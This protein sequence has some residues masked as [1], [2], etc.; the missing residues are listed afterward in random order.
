VTTL[1]ITNLH[2]VDLA[3]EAVGEEEPLVP[4]GAHN[5]DDLGG[6]ADVREGEVVRDSAQENGAVLV[7]EGGL[8]AATQSRAQPGDGVTD[9]ADTDAI[10]RV[11]AY[12]IAESITDGA[13]VVGL[14]PQNA[15]CSLGSLSVSE[16]R[17]GTLEQGNESGSECSAGETDTV[18]NP[19]R[20]SRREVTYSWVQ[21]IH[22]S[23]LKMVK[24]VQGSRASRLR[25]IALRI[26][27]QRSECAVTPRER[28]SK[29]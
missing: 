7:H 27:N 2:R 9:L 3:V 21:I 1:H 10:A 16:Q 26:I 22:A 5:G 24:M 8:V 15:G 6:G 13:R 4:S 25:S 18:R 28:R 17:N 23:K 14:D 11:Q 20:F 29:H 19:E 12:V